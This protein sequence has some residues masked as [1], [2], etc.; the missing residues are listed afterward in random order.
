MAATETETL[1]ECAGVMGDAALEVEA[2]LDRYADDPATATLI[3]MSREAIEGILKAHELA[4][5]LP[6]F[7]RRRVPRGASADLDALVARLAS[8]QTTLTTDR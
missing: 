2:H 7:I 5:L 8:L 3:A 6:G 1:L 4:T